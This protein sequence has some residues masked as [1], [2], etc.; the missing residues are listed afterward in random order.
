MNCQKLKI[1]RHTHSPIQQ[2]RFQHVHLDI[3]GPK[4]PSDTQIRISGNFYKAFLPLTRSDTCFKVVFTIILL[5]VHRSLQSL[6]NS[7]LKNFC[8]LAV[9]YSFLF[10]SRM[11]PIFKIY[12]D[13]LKTTL[14]RYFSSLLFL[15]SFIAFI[16]YFC[17]S[18]FENKNMFAG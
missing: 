4:P 8:I 18:N 3:V 13:N 14:V 15:R 16:Y 17:Y 7:I 10:I 11:C 6:A 9:I 5:F 12:F 2:E 1:Q